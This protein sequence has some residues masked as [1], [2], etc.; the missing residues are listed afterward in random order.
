MKHAFSR[1]DFLTRTAAVSSL[2]LV[3]PNLLG[4]TPAPKSKY[5][6]CAFEKPLQFLSYD[7][8]AELMAS[9]GLDGIEAAVRDKGHVLPEK[10]EQDLPRMHEA[11][12]KRGLEISI[13][14]SSINS[15][16]SPH[17]E[18][19]LRTAA[20]LGIKRYRLLWYAYDLSKPILPQL[21]AIRPKLAKLVALN[22]ELGL[23]ALY[24]N[25][26]GDKMVGAPLWDIYSLIKDFDPKEMALAYD[27]RHATV[28]GGLSW[29]I[30]FNLVKSHLGAVCVKDFVWDQGKVKNVPLGEGVVDKKF[31][32]MLKETKF[33]GP[34]SVHVE[35]LEH[36]KD[37]NAIGEAFRKDLVTTKSWL[38]G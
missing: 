12:K 6:F 15:V 18:K 13:L 35:Y 24:Q 10:V 37:K 33:D 2:A 17:A 3:A 26:S 31:F 38:E 1:R 14:T 36:S 34:V 4:E 7:E 25:H 32:T 22:R 11:L 20:K 30:Q 28:E 27:I 29:P 19:V 5:K 8:L 16:E 9:I 23:T 21:D